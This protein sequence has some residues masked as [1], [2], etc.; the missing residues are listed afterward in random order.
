MNKLLSFPY[1]IFSYRF[2]M[3]H[4]CCCSAQEPQTASSEPGP[5]SELA[6]CSLSVTSLS[7]TFTLGSLSIYGRALHFLLTDGAIPC[8]HLSCSVCVTD[9]ERGKKVSRFTL[10]GR[11]TWPWLH[12]FT[13]GSSGFTFLYWHT[14]VCFHANSVSAYTPLFTNGGSSFT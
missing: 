5:G 2:W 6:A 4:G 3:P 12:L 8:R 10:Q 11:Q 13:G 1:E 7:Q 14:D 9:R